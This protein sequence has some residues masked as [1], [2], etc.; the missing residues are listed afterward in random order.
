MSTSDGLPVAIDMSLAVRQIGD[1]SPGGPGDS[2]RCALSRDVVEAWPAADLSESSAP[3]L[4]N[5]L[6]AIRAI[7]KQASRI[8]RII[9]LPGLF[10]DS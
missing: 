6:Q 9:I 5:V 1:R 7:T 2:V 10:L 4:I 3:E 8:V